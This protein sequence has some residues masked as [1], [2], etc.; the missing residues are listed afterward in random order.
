[1]KKILCG[2]MLKYGECDYG[3]ECYYAHN[4]DEQY[5]EPNRKRIIN[6][7]KGE[8]L[9]DSINLLNK[10]TFDNLSFY[11]KLCNDCIDKKC[12][13]GYNCKYG[14]CDIKLCICYKDFFYGKCS[15]IV[16]NYVH[17]TH[18]KM[19]PYMTQIK[20]NKCDN[21]YNMIDC[22]LFFSMNTIS[23]T[24]TDSYESEDVSTIIDYINNNKN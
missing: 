9:L 2:N 7:I 23:S 22:R 18:R 17:L 20:R 14:A 3:D 4:L 16:C 15:K 21:I 11:T 5:I 1:M 19:V 6:I 8:F 10:N 24:E 13:G 12:L